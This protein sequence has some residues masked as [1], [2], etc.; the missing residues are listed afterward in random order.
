MGRKKTDKVLDQEIE[1]EPEVCVICL[2]PMLSEKTFFPPGD[3]CSH[4]FCPS[5]LNE[6]LANSHQPNC[7]VCRAKLGG[8]R[9][10]NLQ[11][12]GDVSGRFVILPGDLDFNPI[13]TRED[14]VQ[15]YMLYRRMQQ[16]F[17]QE[18]HDRAFWETLL[19]PEVYSISLDAR[20][21]LLS[22]MER[23]NMAL[24]GIDPSNLSRAENLRIIEQDT[25]ILINYF[26][27]LERRRP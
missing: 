22:Y 24:D 2:E 20:G 4:S 19:S 18:S 25:H 11:I 10:I 1:E 17:I 7:P 8:F 13:N 12:P 21:W 5:C 27:Q 3:G 15:L 23:I 16:Y 9:I 14:R 6:W 26:E